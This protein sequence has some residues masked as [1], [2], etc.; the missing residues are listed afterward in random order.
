MRLHRVFLDRACV[1]LLLWAA[2]TIVSPAQT[3]TTQASFDYADGALPELMSLV[4]GTDGNFYGTTLAG[5]AN[6]NSGTVFKITSGGTL[7]TLYNFCSET[8][9]A[10]GSYPYAG[11]VQATDGNFYGTTDGGGAHGAGTVFKITPGGPLTTLYSFCSQPLCFD[12]A[13]PYAGLIQATDGNFYGTTESGGI[14]SGTVFEISPAGAL[15]TLHVFAPECS[16]GSCTE[17]AYPFAPLVEATNGNFYGTTYG[18]GATEN[19]TIFELTSSGALTTLYSFCTKTDCSDGS[20]P[21]GGLVQ[22]TNGVFY[23]T[24]SSG[25]GPSTCGTVFKMAAA[26]ALTTL[27][28]FNCAN[29]VNPYAGLIQGTDGNFYGTTYGGGAKVGG[30]VFKITAGGKL[31]TLYPFCE[32]TNCTDGSNPSGGLTQATNGDFY[33]TTTLGGADGLG[34]VFSMATGLGPFVETRPTS[35]KVGSAVTILGNN[36]TNTTGVTFNGTAATFNIVSSS[37]ITANVPAG[38]TTGTVEVTAPSGKLSS[39]VAFRVTP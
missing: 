16:Q 21:Y 30:T 22:A 27:R 11:L 4:Q 23:G 17:G 34:A 33:G 10:D 3:F 2:T 12:G 25:G 31:T 20:Q 26:S 37:E 36:L 8:N 13:N 7:T 35:G 29:G 5:G 32:Q 19:G 1:V 14:G 18:G 9:C 15:T 39:N 6:Q 24:T 38:A 28:S